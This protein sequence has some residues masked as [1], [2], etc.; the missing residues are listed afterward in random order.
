MNSRIIIESWGGGGGTAAPM[1]E[2]PHDISIDFILYLIRTHLCP[3]ISL[4]ILRMT[5]V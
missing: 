4:Y 3:S 2:P 1:G 5:Q